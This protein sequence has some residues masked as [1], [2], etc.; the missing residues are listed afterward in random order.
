MAHLPRSM[1]R[2]RSLQKGKS[3]PV[4][5]TS[6]PQ[7]GHLRD[8]ILAAFFAGIKGSMRWRLILWYRFCRVAE[9]LQFQS[10]SRMR[11]RRMARDVRGVGVG[12]C[13]FADKP[14]NSNRNIFNY[15]QPI[16]NKPCTL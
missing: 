2:Q 10:V 16:A 15:L 13:V 11:Q 7:E 3:S 14:F 8:L 5:L 4:A 6:A 1:R 9:I 12:V